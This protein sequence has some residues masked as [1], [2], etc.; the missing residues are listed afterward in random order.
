MKT[1]KKKSEG[2]LLWPILK[3]IKTAK[4]QVDYYVRIDRK[5][6]KWNEIKFP[7]TDLHDDVR[8]QWK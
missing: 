7:E 4:L 1:F 2:D 6:D 5:V 3:I 8:Q